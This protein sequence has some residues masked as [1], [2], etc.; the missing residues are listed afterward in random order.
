MPVVPRE[1]AI[2]EE[3]LKYKERQELALNERVA[4][5]ASIGRVST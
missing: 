3:D 2:G 5:I 4:G 1:G